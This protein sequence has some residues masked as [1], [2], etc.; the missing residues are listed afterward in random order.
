MSRTPPPPARAGDL[1][2]PSPLLSAPQR[3]HAITA[4][5]MPAV[6]ASG[7][8]GGPTQGTRVPR[9][10][11]TTPEQL[12]KV[13][14]EFDE[15]LDAVSTAGA[16]VA[17][18]SSDYGV[19]AGRGAAQHAASPT[20]TYKPSAVPKGAAAIPVRADGRI[21]PSLPQQK[22]SVMH[23]FNITD[24]ILEVGCSLTTLGL[25]QRASA[26][27]FPWHWYS[28]RSVG[29]RSLI[30]AGHRT[31]ARMVRSESARSTGES[32]Q[33]CAYRR[34]FHRCAA[35]TP[36]HHSVTARPAR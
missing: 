33:I 36:R 4:P 18:S 12:Q 11:V 17:A 20:S 34:H 13:L 27:H 6:E 29:A 32:N 31:L 16:G 25:A 10:E 8:S 22:A 15:R 19:F 30:A 9:K 26:S 3:G 14:A 1:S 2:S 24:E 23:K 5:S 35:R 21:A 28:E 7:L